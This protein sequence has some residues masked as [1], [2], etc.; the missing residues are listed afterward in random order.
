MCWGKF[1]FECSASRSI[2][3]FTQNLYLID[4]KWTFE[5]MFQYWFAKIVLLVCFRF[6]A[7]LFL[8]VVQHS[9]FSSLMFVCLF[10]SVMGIWGRIY[11]CDE[12][13]IKTFFLYFFCVSQTQIIYIFRH[14]LVVHVEFCMW[15]NS[16]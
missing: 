14:H 13:K 4:K 2:K 1:S 16:K 11:L 8:L 3:F 9:W 5:I 12:N 7:I 10:N 15:I 6:F